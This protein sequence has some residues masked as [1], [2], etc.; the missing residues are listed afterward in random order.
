[1][2]TGMKELLSRSVEQYQQLFDLTVALEQPLQ[3]SAPDIISRLTNSIEEIKKEIVRTDAVISSVLDSHPRT[4]DMELFRKRIDLMES[5]LQKN[6]KLTPRIQAMMALHD[7][8][9]NK[10]RHGRQSI[11]SYATPAGRSGRIIDTSN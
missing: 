11:G 7:S 1:M 5:I 10:I 3:D 4:S 9:L 2:E 8:E 6:R